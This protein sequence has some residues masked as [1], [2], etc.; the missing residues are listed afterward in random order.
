MSSS[1]VEFF[2]I[3]EICWL[4]KP[5]MVHGREV[6]EM[7]TVYVGLRFRPFCVLLLEKK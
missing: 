3:T 5:K 4:M 6:T 2:C 1:F 7:C